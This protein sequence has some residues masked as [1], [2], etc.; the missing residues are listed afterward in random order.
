[1][2]TKNENPVQEVKIDAIYEPKEGNNLDFYTVQLRAITEKQGTTSL[3]SRLLGG[4]FEEKR[5]AFQSIK[6][7]IADELE[8]KK[9]D[10]LGKK[11][12]VPVRLTIKE[13]TESELTLMPEKG[14]ID[15]FNKPSFKIKV[16][17][18][19]LNELSTTEGEAIYRAVKMT[20]IDIEDKYVQHVKV[21]DETSTKE[22]AA[23]TA[24]DEESDK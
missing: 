24:F 23:N 10:N 8:L 1:M 22:M 14:S 16:T 19:G 6:K 7:S 20:S 12:G 21:S 18:D 4:S 5:V 15:G 3:N 17:P 9:G 11:L 2:E 13:V